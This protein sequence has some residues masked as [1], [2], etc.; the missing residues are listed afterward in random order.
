MPR[1]PGLDSYW[2]YNQVNFYPLVLH[3][4]YVLI[5]ITLEHLCYSLTYVM[6]QLNPPPG[7]VSRIP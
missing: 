6:S 4:I 5:E 3:D 7:G 2:K 1:F